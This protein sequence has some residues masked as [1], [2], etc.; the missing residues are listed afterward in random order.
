MCRSRNLAFPEFCFNSEEVIY[1]TARQLMRLWGLSFN[2]TQ[3]VSL[4]WAFFFYLARSTQDFCLLFHSQ[5]EMH[6]NRFR[7]VGREKKLI[8]YKNLWYAQGR[9]KI[10]T[11]FNHV[12]DWYVLWANT[13]KNSPWHCG[14]TKMWLNPSGKARN[15]RVVADAACNKT[16]SGTKTSHPAFVTACYNMIVRGGCA[17]RP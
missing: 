17:P 3:K 10:L 6:V 9:L 12:Q 11:G 4:H 13:L 5:K 14:V 15:S 2:K 8:F 1:G 16:F 7:H